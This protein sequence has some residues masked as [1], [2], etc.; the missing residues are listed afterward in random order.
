MRARRGPG[1]TGSL[2]RQRPAPEHNIIQRP[3]LIRALQQR[4]G[5]RQA[6]IAPV[7]AESIQPVVIVDTLPQEARI[8]AAPYMANVLSTNDAGIAV[9]GFT[10]FNK[11]ASGRRIR[12]RRMHVRSFDIA[13]NV[14]NISFTIAAGATSNPTAQPQGQLCHVRGV[15]PLPTSDLQSMPGQGCGSLIAWTAAPPVANTVMEL[16]TQQGGTVQDH[17]APGIWTWEPIELWIYPNGGISWWWDGGL[18][19]PVQVNSCVEWT[20]EQIQS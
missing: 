8:A 17:R 13:N 18:T 20:E 5:M 19:D 7:L 16:H 1:G 4:L 15:D 14:M 12:V 2:P 6:H 10:L 9:A 11:A 3:E